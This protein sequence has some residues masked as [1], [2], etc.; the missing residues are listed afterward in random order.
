MFKIEAIQSI[1][2][3]KAFASACGTV[4]V[5]GCFAYAMYDVET[6]Q[7]TGFSQFDIAEGVGHIIDLKEAKGL[8]DFE[9]MFILGRST[10][11]FIDLC[12]AHKA[13][14]AIEAGE[15]T[16]L[17]AIGFKENENGYF[18]DMTGFFSGNCG[19]H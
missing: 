12:G 7:P 1:E 13:T 3:Q 8:S 5:E 15:P 2:Q 11:N 10:M 4:A 16:L 9:A 19:N 14:A 18:C 17:K 6:K